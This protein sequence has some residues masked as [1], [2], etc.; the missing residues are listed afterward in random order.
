MKTLKIESLPFERVT[1]Q[2]DRPAETDKSGQDSL[3]RTA[4]T[5]LPRQGQTDSQ[6]ITGQSLSL[7]SCNVFKFIVDFHE[8]TIENV[9][10]SKIRKGQVLRATAFRKAEIANY[11]K[12]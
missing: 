3:E 10:L 7:S 12:S 2:A 9:N 8:W 5:G 1:E 11:N 4:W 6:A